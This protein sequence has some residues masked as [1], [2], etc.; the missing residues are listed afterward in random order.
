[1]TAADY[2]TQG[3]AQHFSESLAQLGRDGAH[4]DRIA[5]LAVLKWRALDNAL[6]PIIGHGG[7]AALFKRSVSLSRPTH[8]WLAS[9]QEGADQPHNF[10]ALQSALCQQTSS[11]AAAA[12][13]SLQQHFVDLL[14]HLIGGSLTE[15]LLRSVWD[16]TS[17]DG[18]VQETSR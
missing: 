18:A 5:A 16:N 13:S 10:A 3:G 6:S 7:V 11:E 2:S 1:M 14:T 17:S 4:P 8:A 15:R 9:L 12:A